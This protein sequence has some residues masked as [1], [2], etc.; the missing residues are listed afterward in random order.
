MICLN[1]DYYDE[2]DLRN[3]GI[4]KV[5]AYV[6]IAKTCTIV[7]LDN[8]EIGNNVRIDAN[9]VLTATNPERP[10]VIG[11]Y[12]HIGSNCTI[13]G[14]AGFEMKDFQVFLMESV[15]LQVLM[16][17]QVNIFLVP[18]YLKTCAIQSQVLLFLKS[19]C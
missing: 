6:R 8:I 14:N 19:M 9:C 10:M 12:I 11:N 2:N 7:G 18:Q 4:K 16:I 13:L 17:F 5:G 1:A 15:F 3:I